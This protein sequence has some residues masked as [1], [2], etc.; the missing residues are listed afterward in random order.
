MIGERKITHLFPDKSYFYPK[1]FQNDSSVYCTGCQF[2]GGKKLNQRTE[3]FDL[4]PDSRLFF[5]LFFFTLLNIQSMQ[6]KQCTF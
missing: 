4:P 3:L 2:G 6:K 1:T 5:F